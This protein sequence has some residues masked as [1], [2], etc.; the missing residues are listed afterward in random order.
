MI[1]HCVSAFRKEQ[2]EK[3]YRIYVTDCLKAIAEN[4]T[5]LVGLDGVVEYGAKISERWI[6]LIEPKAKKID[7]NETMTCEEIVTGI[8][9][10][11]KKRR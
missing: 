11:M 6:D 9:K 8:W 1:D 2:E 4:T 3:S 10:R 7:Q 5:H